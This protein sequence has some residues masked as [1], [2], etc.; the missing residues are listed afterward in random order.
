[1]TSNLLSWD[2]FQTK[3]T[4]KL[5]KI[6]DTKVHIIWREAEKHLTR[7]C[8]GEPSLIYVHFQCRLRLQPGFFGGCLWNLLLYPTKS[9][10]YR[11]MQ[12][13]TP[14]PLCFPHNT[15]LT[16]MFSSHQE[17]INQLDLINNL[18]KQMQQT[19][20]YLDIIIAFSVYL[21]VI[22]FNSIIDWKSKFNLSWKYMYC[23]FRQYTHLF[24]TMVIGPNEL[25]FTIYTRHKN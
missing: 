12:G 2:F 21:L 25:L 4:F 17:F 5:C 7:L 19:R 20:V 13:Y 16:P 18:K 6:A 14:H 15:N 11:S 9:P 23:H 3:V 1:M 24:Q 22:S 8:P 10:E